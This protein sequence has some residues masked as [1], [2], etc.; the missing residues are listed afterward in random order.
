MT[1]ATKEANYSMEYR[2][3]LHTGQLVA[4]D[5]R[6]SPTSQDGWDPAV[7]RRKRPTQINRSKT[8]QGVPWIL[9]PSKFAW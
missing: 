8:K 9:D 1:K 4:S 6:F 5:L 3:I 7:S 2:C